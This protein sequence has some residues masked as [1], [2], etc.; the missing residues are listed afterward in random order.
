MNNVKVSSTIIAHI[1]SN[2]C[3]WMD[4]TKNDEWNVRINESAN[5]LSFMQSI[6]IKMTGFCK[7]DLQKVLV[8]NHFGSLIICRKLQSQQTDQG[9]NLFIRDS[10]RPK[11][12][13][14]G[15][16]PL[17][18]CSLRSPSVERGVLLPRPHPRPFLGLFPG[19]GSPRSRDEARSWAHGPGYTASQGAEDLALSP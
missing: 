12:C 4:K 5:A 2:R 14:L 6:F 9:K 3:Q 1:F 18:R 10:S 11:L 16:G 19:G 17:P 15:S 13:K 8:C 7:L